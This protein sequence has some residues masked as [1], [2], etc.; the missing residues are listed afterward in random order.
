MIK[1]KFF[2]IPAI[3]IITISLINGPTYAVPEEMKRTKMGTEEQVR[4]DR[5]REE[6]FIK[7]RQF[8]E[9]LRK[10]ARKLSENVKEKVQ[11]GLE[12]LPVIQPKK[13]SPV[14]ES[15]SLT[16]AKPK[17]TRILWPGLP[18]MPRFIGPSKVQPEDTSD[19][20]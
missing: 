14:K 9:G 20:R 2:F 17:P 8:I 3:L 1:D 7:K 4:E 16:E 18:F 13:K 12:F 11:K 5:R 15:P 10:M 19:S 6:E